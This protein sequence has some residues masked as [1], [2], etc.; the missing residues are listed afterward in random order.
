MAQV[1]SK[2][3][4][5]AGASANG[6]AHLASAQPDGFSWSEVA[7]SAPAQVAIAVMAL[8]GLGASIYLTVVH[9][10]TKVSLVCTSGG[11]VNCGNVTTSAW[12]VVPGTP[13]PVTIPGMLWF[14]VSGG[15]ALVG[16]WRLRIGRAEPARLRL[17][18][19]VWGLG[20][21]LFVIYLIYCE[22]VLVHNICEWCTAVHILTFLTFILAFYRLQHSGE[23]PDMAVAQ[24]ATTQAPST[25]QAR[26]MA[27]SRRARRVA[28]NGSASS[29]RNGRRG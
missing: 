29:G 15:L 18:Q 21:L 24:S 3:K 13:I 27:L 7:R 2:D 14:V 1:R 6:V 19:F 25:R 4:I 11:L 9:Y 22:I 20:G 12:S 10:D 8:L 28:N 17:T 26:Q 16:L 23:A 5:T